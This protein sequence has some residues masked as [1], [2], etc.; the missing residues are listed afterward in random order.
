MI[1]KNSLIPTAFLVFGL[2][3]GIFAFLTEISNN[4]FWIGSSFYLQMA[5]ASILVA[6]YFQLAK[7][8]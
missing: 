2:L 3:C 4:I 6:I 7:K 8:A 5:M 1:T